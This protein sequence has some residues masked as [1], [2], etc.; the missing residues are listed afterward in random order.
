MQEDIT[1]IFQFT[2][3]VTK[4]PPG[5]IRFAKAKS[6][7]DRTY[8]LV[9]VVLPG[10]R[11]NITVFQHPPQEGQI[12]LPQHVNDLVRYGFGLFIATL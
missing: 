8:S 11:N 5:P 1:S 12:L 3:N 4:A 7:Q 10:L 6:Y 9:A 2:A